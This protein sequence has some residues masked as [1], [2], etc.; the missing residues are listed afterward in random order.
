MIIEKIV[1][2]NWISFFGEHSIDLSIDDGSNGN[3][4]LI[5]GE[6][7][8][9]KTSLTSALRWVISG[10]I[11]MERKV[12]A[13]TAKLPRRLMM[14]DMPKWKGSLLNWECYNQGIYNLNVSIEFVHDE[15]KYLLSRTLK[16]A[17]STKFDASDDKVESSLSLINLNS[18]QDFTDDDAQRR[19]NEFI[20][21]R[22]LKFFVIEGDFIQEYQETLFSSEKNIDMTESVKDAIGVEA[23]HRM[24]G[25][26]STDLSQTKEGLARVK[27]VGARNQ[28]KM[29]RIKYI[30][31]KIKYLKDEV[32]DKKLQIE[33]ERTDLEQIT[34]TLGTKEDA[35]QVLDI[36]RKKEG[37]INGARKNVELLSDNISKTMRNVW[38]M[39]LTPVIQYESA[40]T[41]DL[42]VKLEDLRDEQATVRVQM[43]RMR[44]S[45]KH[46]GICPHCKQDW[47]NTLSKGDAEM[48][49]SKL[50][51]NE[52]NLQK[53]IDSFRKKLRFIETLRSY[54]Q[55]ERDVIKLK[56][57]Y[58][59]LRQ[60]IYEIESLTDDV[61]DLNA[62]LEDDTDVEI[63]E[64]TTL[65][66][67]IEDKISYLEGEIIEIEYEEDNPES[68]M[69]LEKELSNYSKYD[70]NQDSDNKQI[71]RFKKRCTLLTS[72]IEAF[73]KSEKSFMEKMRIV[74]NDH[75]TE[76]FQCL[77]TDPN[78]KPYF[79]RL[80][81]SADWSVT[82][83][84]NT[85]D[86]QPVENPGHMLR[87][88]LAYLGALR[89]SA[90][91]EFPVVLDNPAAPLDQPG[92]NALAELLIGN[93][94][95]QTILLT[96]S[97]GYAIDELLR[98]YGD[99]IART[100]ILKTST[101]GVNN[102]SQ[103]VTHGGL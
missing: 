71:K 42:R 103:I 45:E 5:H 95:N 98:V 86:I 97:G 36:I 34:N 49:L 58:N 15:T 70:I 89:H 73:S 7:S 13:H 99:S 54:S 25:A 68:I 17:D 67:R 80:E 51:T 59:L 20:P 37:E 56:H 52:D 53:M 72:L 82:C 90:K 91:I 62:K 28:D 46:R 26:L 14:F 93:A 31:N 96:H 8:K 47:K 77:I 18:K 39:I 75:M 35:K 85:G 23:L 3:V 92:R 100:Y 29:D 30:S 1:L 19:I 11:K 33:V 79:H 55:S 84:T 38:K 22:L 43:N 87:G 44:N 12:G 2:N 66:I 10:D 61:D 50:L 57:D 76:Q 102:R 74:L 69:R 81:A 83:K 48:E 63:Q 88:T 41:D 27:N 94:D 4:I 24:T 65:K 6:T 21:E 64:L 16:P 9:G 40:L 60:F 32:K 101:E 78:E